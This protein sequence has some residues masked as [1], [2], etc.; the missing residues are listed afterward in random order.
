MAERF[1]P[2]GPWSRFS[3]GGGFDTPGWRG[4]TCVFSLRLVGKPA[5]GGPIRGR[6]QLTGVVS[7]PTSR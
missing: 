2:S 5:A 3:V 4:D 1:P 7:L 6:S